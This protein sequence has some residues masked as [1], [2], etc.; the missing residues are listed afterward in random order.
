[1]TDAVMK[2]GLIIFASGFSASLVGLIVMLFC[3]IIEDLL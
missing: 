1:M 2:G 3:K